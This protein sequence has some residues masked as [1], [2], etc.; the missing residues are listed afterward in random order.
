M[1]Q[2]FAKLSLVQ[3]VKAGLELWRQARGDAPQ[4]PIRFIFEGVEYEVSG[5]AYD[6]NLIVLPDGRVIEPAGWF[7]SLPPHPAFNVDCVVDG[8]QARQIS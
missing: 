5:V 2:E 3:R 8:L 4:P 1:L 6:A 7:D